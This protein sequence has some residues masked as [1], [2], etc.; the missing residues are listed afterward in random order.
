M[1]ILAISLQ[2]HQGKK[3]NFMEIFKTSKIEKHWG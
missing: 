2:N 1:P 3:K